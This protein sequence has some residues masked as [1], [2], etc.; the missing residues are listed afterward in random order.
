MTGHRMFSLLLAAGITA[1]S[2][3]SST[4]TIR[5]YEG[6]AR[7]DSETAVLFTARKGTYPRDHVDAVLS[8]ING[9]NYGN[10]MNGYPHASRVLAG[11]ATVKVFCVDGKY[12]E[13]QSFKLMTAHFEPGHFY[14]LTCDEFE[15]SAVDRGTDRTAIAKILPDKIP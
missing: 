7:P 11:D 3:C 10:F 1:F 13:I 14:E 9:T 4:H 6:A 8:A 15:P 12:A 2:A 5:A